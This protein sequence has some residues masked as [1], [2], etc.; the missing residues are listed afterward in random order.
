MLHVIDVANVDGLDVNRRHAEGLEIRTAPYAEIFY[1]DDV[2]APSHEV[3]A[4][5]RA[6]EAATAGHHCLSRGEAHASSSP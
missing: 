4:Q 3:R 1:D 2:F 6:D 5:V